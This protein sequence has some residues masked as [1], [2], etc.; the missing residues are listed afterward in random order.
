VR[1][2]T[3]TH[4]NHRKQATWCGRPCTSRFKGLSWDERRGYWT[5]KIKKQQITRWLGSY[6]DEIAAAHAYDE[7][8]RNCSA[9]TPG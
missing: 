9:S 6:H 4:A 7:A 2:L 3:Q 5:A 1:T 8:A